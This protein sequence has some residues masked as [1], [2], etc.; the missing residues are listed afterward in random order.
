[1]VACEFQKLIEKVIKVFNKQ[2]SK[3]IV[4]YT[5]GSYEEITKVNVSPIAPVVPI[6]PMQPYRHYR[7]MMCGGDHGAN[8]PCPNSNPMSNTIPCVGPGCEDSGK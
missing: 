5:D 3:V 7:C 1:M 6:Q 2:I 4:Y 8:I